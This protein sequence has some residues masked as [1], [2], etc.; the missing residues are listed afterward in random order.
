M[1]KGCRLPPGTPAPCRHTQV[2]AH[3]GAGKANWRGGGTQTSA[4]GSWGREHAQ[5]AASR[6]LPAPRPPLHTYLLK[7]RPGMLGPIWTPVLTS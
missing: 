4:K 6:F 2:Q 3:S 7:L 5:E 1:G